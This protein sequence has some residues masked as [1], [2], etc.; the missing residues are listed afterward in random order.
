MIYTIAPSEISGVINAPASKSIAQ[1][2]IAAA[3]LSNGVTNITGYSESDDSVAAIDIIKTLGASVHSCANKLEITGNPPKEKA[4]QLTFSSG[5]SGLSSRL[6]APIAL[7]YSTNVLVNGKGSLL[8]RPF[9]DMMQ[10][11]FMQMGIDYSDNNGK[12]PLLLKGNINTKEINVDGSGG[13][14]FLSGILMTLP[15]LSN[16]SV[17]K[18]SNLKSKPYIDMTIDVAAKFGVAI[19][20]NNYEEFHINGQQQ[21]QNTE[22]N[23]EG[24]WSGASCLLVAG[25]I[26]G[27]IK[28]ENLNYNSTQ[29]DKKI[30]DVLRS[31][32]ATVNTGKTSVTIAKNKLEPFVFDA[33]DCPDLFP[34]LAALAANCNGVSKIKGISRLA[35][36]ESNRSLALQSEFDKIGININLFEDYMTIAGAEA[37]GGKVDS[38][39][40]H[41]I[42]MAMATMA[43]NSELPVVVEN[44]ECVNKSYPNFWNDL[45]LCTSG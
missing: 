5:E 14:Q 4:E 42:A 28:I 24:D 38:H 30:I 31:V 43:I 17:V 27:N 15:M 32:G 3:L 45:E 26:G 2:V 37:K 1:R 19:T 35:T 10:A 11:P 40:D 8:K 18:V 23:I 39:N 41:R 44:V 25:A 16:N 29:A 22:Y 20:H 6:F 36:K 9:A 34:A 13:S 21:Y 12:L 33:T 7:L